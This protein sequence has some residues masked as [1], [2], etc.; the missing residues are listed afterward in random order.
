ME[1]GLTIDHT[2]PP[3]PVTHRPTNTR[4]PHPIRPITTIEPVVPVSA[5]TPD[6]KMADM[7]LSSASKEEPAPVMDTPTRRVRGAGPSSIVFG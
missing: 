5:G 2:P 4:P 1:T 3:V 7:S 6:K